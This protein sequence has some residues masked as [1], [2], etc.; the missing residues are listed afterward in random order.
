[1]SNFDFLAVYPAI[2][3]ELATGAER[4]V[5]TDPNASLIK[6]R[7]LSEA[8]ARHACAALNIVPGPAAAHRDYIDALEAR[9]VLKGDVGRLFHA[10][11]ITGNK[12]VHDYTG[13]RVVAMQH[14][15][16]AFR[17]SCWF[18]KSFGGPAAA[19]FKSPPF[20]EPPNPA[21]EGKQQHALLQQTQAE[22]EEAR[23]LVADATRTV[24]EEAQRRAEAEAAAKKLQDESAVYAELAQ[25]ME[26]ALANAKKDFDAQL[27]AVQQQ[28]QAEPAKAVEATLKHAAKEAQKVALS[29]SETRAII[30]AQLRAAGWE[31]DSEH[32][33]HA[34][35]A[36]PIKGQD[37]AIAEWPTETGPADYVLFSGKVPLG[38]VEAKKKNKN[39][40]G[41]IEQAK[42]YSRDWLVEDAADLAGDWDAGKVDGKP[43]RYRV[44]FLYA[45]NGR[46]YLRQVEHQSGIWF[47]DARLSTNHPHALVNWHTPQGLKERLAQDVSVAHAELNQEPTGYLGLRDYQI[48]AIKA[49]EDALA[50]G[51]RSMLVAM[52]TGTGKTRT[53]IGLIYRLLKTKRM[54]R[55]L[56]LVDRTSLGTQAQDAFAEMRLEQNQL[57]TDIYEV[58]EIGDIKPEKETKVHVATVQGMVRRVL[59]EEGPQ[60]PIDA[61]DCV[62]VDEAHRG[63]TLDRDMGEG[64]MQLRDQADYISSYRRV[65]DH[66]D[67]TKVGLTA[68]PALHTRQIFGDAVFEYSYRRAVAEGWLVD[69]EPP[70][71]IS[72][73][74]STGGIR[75][76]KGEQVQVLTAPGQLDLWNMEEDVRFEVEDFHRKVITEN[77]NRV[78]CQELAKYLDPVGD[79]KTLVFCVNDAHADMVVNL[80]TEALEQEHGPIVEGTV[81]K[82]TGSI[83]DPALAI[84]LLKNEANPRIAVTVDLLTTGI[85]VP[86]VCNL[87][88]MR[89]VKSRILYEQMMGRATRRCDEIGKEVFRIFDVVGLY[90]EMQKVSEMQPVVQQVYISTE[91]LVE[92]L[93]DPQSQQAPGTRPGKTHAEDVLAQLVAR[94]QRLARRAAGH[95]VAPDSAE[96]VSAAEELA[97]MSLE[98]LARTLGKADVAQAVGL[99]ASNPLLVTALS[100]ATAGGV[101]TQPTF[102]SDDPDSVTKVEH[103][104]GEG[105]LRPED[106]L[107]AFGTFI[108]SNK[109]RLMALTVVLQRPRDLTRAQLQELRLALGTAGYS[110][111]VLRTAYRDLKNVDVAAG[112]LGFIRQQAL[113]SPLVPYVDR[114]DAALDRILGGGAWTGPQQKW[115]V[116]IAKQLKQDVILEPATFEQGAF[117]DQGGVIAAEK[118]FDGRL[119]EVL[120]DVQ[121][122][123]WDDKVA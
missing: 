43:Q 87:V 20:V 98:T 69:H 85:D 82:I 5:H 57:F 27:A 88:F 72:T 75:F 110:E 14:L 30:D 1:M 37:R 53:V 35:G 83:D 3:K 51:Q 89:R 62:I 121:D 119:A 97:G 109:N 38:V 95:K 86:K 73:E 117:K 101:G 68:T 49:V 17:L 32:L 100:K 6:M 64:E 114:V 78:V 63:Y 36:R 40:P 113:G 94:L 74:L 31:A 70:M 118:V 58:K 19:S 52:A 4:T 25:E 81:M 90:S 42:R 116:R 55:V 47:L 33:K 29:E 79:Q 8:L 108:Q 13:N 92:E 16:L 65:L 104:Y 23:R 59:D 96:A 24:G 50:N 115:L 22:L 39:I 105:N 112:I 44:P 67:A 103:G 28:A 41:A 66:F 11:R 102:V 71:Q 61:Y 10:L 123:I 56:F 12:A 7:Q 18:H 122:A 107:E 48:A 93:L 111:Q 15:H 2:F 99:F 77:F 46:P 106:F 21:L 84:R 60:L 34:Q 76:K 54:T 26:A 120:G 80:L 91:R 45:T 9:G